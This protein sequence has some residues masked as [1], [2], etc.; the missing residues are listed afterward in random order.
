MPFSLDRLSLLKRGHDA[1]S[2]RRDFVEFPLHGRFVN[3][4]KYW[5]WL[6]KRASSLEI[7]VTAPDLW[8]ELP[9]RLF[10]SRG[11]KLHYFGMFVL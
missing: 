1:A 9:L 11:V 8:S 4:M 3:R 5:G 7:M 2:V 6:Y 10:M